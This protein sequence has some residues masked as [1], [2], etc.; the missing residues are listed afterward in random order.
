M[1]MVEWYA[2]I[3]QQ[4]YGPVDEP[5]LQSWVTQGRLGP[6]DLIWS[7]G[8]AAWTQA[9]TVFPGWFGQSP[10]PL[11]HVMPPP[12]MPGVPTGVPG[13]PSSMLWAKPHRGG[14]IL[15]FGILGLIN[16]GCLP[17][18][19]F[20]ILAW[21]MGNGDLREMRAGHMDPAGMGTTSAGRVC[22]IIGVVL[23]ILGLIVNLVVLGTAFRNGFDFPMGP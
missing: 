3:G 19:V 15:T 8:Q 20:S 5:T 10:P 2:H 23:A 12:G 7:P 22:G 16:L 13:M 9:A 17:L 1:G 21:V 6:Y 18:G 4:Q 11:T 14:L